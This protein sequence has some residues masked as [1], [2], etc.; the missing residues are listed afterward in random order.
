MLTPIHR[1]R[2]LETCYKL[3]ADVGCSGV[4]VLRSAQDDILSGLAWFAIAKSLGEKSGLLVIKGH[5][6]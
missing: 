4:E 1:Q 2:A 5:N 3:A 6:G